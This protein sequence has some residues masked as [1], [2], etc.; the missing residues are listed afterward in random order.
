MATILEFPMSRP[1]PARNRWSA[2]EDLHAE[3]IE[4][5]DYRPSPIQRARDWQ[6]MRLFNA[7]LCLD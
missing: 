5:S 7:N 1:T 3:I 2:D 6:A 4:L